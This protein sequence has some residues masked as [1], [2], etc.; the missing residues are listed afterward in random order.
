MRKKYER[1]ILA[2]VGLAFCAIVAA[3][4]AAVELD[5]S[6]DR[7]DTPFAPRFKRVGTLRPRSTMEIRSS[8]WMVGCECNDRDLVDFEKYK[9]FLPPL[10]VKTIRLMGGWQKCEQ[11][12]GVYDFAWLDREVDFANAN[13]INVY[14]GLEYG[15]PI[16]PGGGGVDLAGQFPNGEVALAA[17]DRWV[18]AMTKHFKGR[19]RDWSMW[20]EPD[21]NP[22]ALIAEFNVRTAKI[23]KRN[24][25]DARIGGFTFADIYL[26]NIEPCLEAAG[27]DLS[28]F[29]WFV[30]HGYTFAPE[31]VYD[32]VEELRKVVK[33]A[34]PA[35]KLRQGENGCPS[36]M[37]PHGWALNGVPWSEY[38]QAK[39]ILRRVL[40]DLGHDIESAVFQIVDFYNPKRNVVSGVF[41]TK[42]L[43]RTD[44]AKNV[45]DVKLAY[46]AVQNLASVFDDRWSRVRDSKLTTTDLGVV[47]YEHVKDTGERLYLF[48]RFADRAVPAT[49]PLSCM[50]PQVAGLE[51]PAVRPGDSFEAA[52]QVFCVRDGSCL[53]DP[54]FVDLL[55]GRVYEFPLRKVAASEDATRYIGVPLYDS[56]CFLTERSALDLM[57]NCQP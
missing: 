22:P 26:P 9:R 40:G 55:S 13:G 25:P 44:L 6:A 20:N 17:W 23:V 27:K 28:L 41:N 33:H 15:N 56:P 49:H 50:N 29:H 30:Y 31:T 7:A 10:G 45:I 52:P 21:S 37:V 34:N 16:Y 47:V 35:L 14:L 8:N 2:N 32:R 24:I 57:E 19:V 1:T 42:G 18:D 38:S 51:F 12:K 48:W 43:L 53:K 11:E 46:Y 39:W 54:V 4:A 3:T 5:V 36:E